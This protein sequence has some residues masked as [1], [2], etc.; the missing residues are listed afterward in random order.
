MNRRDILMGGAMLTASGAALALTPRNRL[1]LLDDDRSL[2]AIVPAKLGNWT[3][4]P[5]D[6]F[7][8]PKTEGSL[9]DRI[10]NQTL[11]RLY[12]APDA[13]PVMLVIAYGAVQNDQLQLHRPEVCYSAVGFEIASTRVETLD[14]GRSAMLPLRELEATSTTRI[15]SIVYWTRIGDDLPTD[16]S[17][18]RMVKLRQQLSGYLADGVLVRL[19]TVA[20][21]SPE[22]FRA[23]G[24]FATSMID[25][26]APS[27]RDV[28]IGRPLAKLMQ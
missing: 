28:L 15:E 22:V 27:D 1:V 13:M 20:P 26:I 4:A 9:S 14:L 16:G 10:Y 2:E 7:V 8:L 18:Q 5:S 19:S 11:T 25:A 6:A 17:S 12:V 21:A 24:S 23:L 3:S